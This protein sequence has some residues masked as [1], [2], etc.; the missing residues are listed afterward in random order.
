MSQSAKKNIRNVTESIEKFMEKC[1]KSLESPVTEDCF[2]QLDNFPLSESSEM[3]KYQ[4]LI[5]C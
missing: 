1:L 2:P 4:M 5:G 3:A